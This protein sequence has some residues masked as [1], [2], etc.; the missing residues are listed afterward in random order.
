MLYH[1]FINNH[2]TLPIIS[3]YIGVVSIKI[4][5]AFLHY[6]K[7]SLFQNDPLIC[8]TPPAIHLTQLHAPVPIPQFVHQQPEHIIHLLH[9]IALH[10]FGPGPASLGNYPFYLYLHLDIQQHL[11]N[12]PR[13]TEPGPEAK[14]G[15]CFQA[16]IEPHLLARACNDVRKGEA[17]CSGAADCGE[18]GA[19]CGAGVGWVPNLSKVTT[20]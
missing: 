5:S 19:V 10:Q 6:P 14:A 16:S 18:A 1:T 12:A 15:G 8:P 9:H 2:I 4:L 17:G 13:L 11:V 20:T 7:W 3:I